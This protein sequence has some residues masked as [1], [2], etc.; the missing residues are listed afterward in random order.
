MK[1]RE[2]GLSIRTISERT[3][4]PKARCKESFPESN[5]GVPDLIPG[6][7]NLLYS[8]CYA[9]SPWE[10]DIV[11]GKPSVLRTLDNTI[12]PRGE[13]FGKKKN[14]KTYTQD[15]TN[16]KKW[17]LHSLLLIISPQ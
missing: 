3:K 12:S 2:D 9:I 8:F 10:D 11:K 13:I 1:L 17:I 15:L 4:F 5:K 6:H 14:K 16:P 7:P